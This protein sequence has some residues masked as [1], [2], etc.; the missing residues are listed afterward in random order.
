M[1]AFRKSIVCFVPVAFAAL[2]TGSAIAQQTT[3]E[4]GL[5]NAT[6]TVDGT[7]LPN[8]PAAFGGVINMR[9]QDSKPFWPP[10]IVPPKGAAQCAA[11]HD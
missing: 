9:A 5:P 8:P 11:H 7:Y 6:T 4:A 10:K 2:W 3:G 1:N